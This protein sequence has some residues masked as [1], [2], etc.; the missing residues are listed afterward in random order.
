MAQEDAAG[1]RP[2]RRAN[3]ASVLDGSRGT[4]QRI[5][6][7]EIACKEKGPIGGSRTP[8]GAG[9][10]SENLLWRAGRHLGGHRH[11]VPAVDQKLAHQGNL[12][13][14][15]GFLAKGGPAIFNATSLSDS[16]PGDSSPWPASR[17]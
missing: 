16:S 13:K 6:W 8:P 14:G 11:G 7:C 3:A 4:G 15:A 5:T 9:N 17:T 12:G 1:R 10:L 2:E